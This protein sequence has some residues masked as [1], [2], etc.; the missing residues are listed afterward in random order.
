MSVRCPHTATKEGWV[1]EGQACQ[2]TGKFGLEALAQEAELDVIEGLEDVG[3]GNGLLARVGGVLVCAV[4]LFFLSARPTM[5]RQKLKER[6]E[7]TRRR[8]G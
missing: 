1:K 7:L 3:G 6:R 8:G 5:N 4:V 2:R